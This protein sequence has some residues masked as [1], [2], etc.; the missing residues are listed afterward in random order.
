MARIMPVAGIRMSQSAASINVRLLVTGIAPG[1]VKF[2]N[3]S[4]CKLDPIRRL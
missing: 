4:L 3:Y 2:F 1:K